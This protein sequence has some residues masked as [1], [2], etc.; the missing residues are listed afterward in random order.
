M[1]YYW[2]IDYITKDNGKVQPIILGNRAFTS[3]LGAQRFLDTVTSTRNV[4]VVELPTRNTA[5]ASQYIRG[6][7][8][9]KAGNTAAGITRVRHK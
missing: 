9:K 5:K 7:L 2:I 1:A 8:V 3:E 6:R 4:E